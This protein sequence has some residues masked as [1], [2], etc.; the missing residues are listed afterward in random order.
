[1]SKALGKRC[2]EEG[3]TELALNIL[4]GFLTTDPTNEEIVRLVYACHGARGDRRG[5]I[6]ADRTLRAALRRQYL[7][8]NEEED[9][10]DESLWEPY[11]E[12]QEVFNRLR[13]ELSARDRG[14]AAR[15]RQDSSSKD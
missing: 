4:E 8:D 10:R 12:T 14:R 7:D 5:L 6:E 2:L 15:G 11:P 9:E 1:M 3:Q 13:E